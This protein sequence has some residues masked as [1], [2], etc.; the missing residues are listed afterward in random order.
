MESL[1][2]SYK[3]FKAALIDCTANTAFCKEKDAT[4]LPILRF[5]QPDKT[6][7]EDFTGSADCVEDCMEIEAMSDFISE[8]IP[9]VVQAVTDANFNNFM[10]PGM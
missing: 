10:A 5:Y 6:E 3:S 2:Q 7:Y 8:S 1:A 9:N 4:S